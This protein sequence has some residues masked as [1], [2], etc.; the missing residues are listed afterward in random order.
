[1]HVAAGANARL[2]AGGRPSFVFLCILV[3]G[4]IDV[5]PSAEDGTTIVGFMLDVALVITIV[6]H[7]VGIEEPVSVKDSDDLT[8]LRCVS[9]DVW[10]F[11]YRF[12]L[13]ISL[14]CTAISFPLFR[15]A[16]CVVIGTLIEQELSLRG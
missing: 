4:G 2:F 1:M 14:C 15:L 5:A 10:G 11:G 16:L 13:L 12:R 8:F 7:G 9:H 3:P 6:E